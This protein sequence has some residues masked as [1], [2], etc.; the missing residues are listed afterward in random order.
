MD[1]NTF[2]TTWVAPVVTGVIVVVITT[3]IGKIVS[4]WW[5]NR[6]FVRNRDRANEKYI[7]NILPYMI[8]KIDVNADFVAS[9][10][11]ALSMQFNLQAKHLYSNEQLK[12]Q[13]ILSISDSKFMTELQ[14]SDLIQYVQS[15]FK[16]IGQDI[17]KVEVSRKE[18]RRANKKYPILMLVISVCCTLIVY[19]IYPEK[20][21]D[22][23]SFAHSLAILGGLFSLGSAATLWMMLLSESTNKINIEIADSGI[24][25]AAYTVVKDVV[26][27]ITEILLGKKKDT[28]DNE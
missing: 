15:T 13:I 27:T 21:D 2:I 9:V 14:K 26:S 4:I 1:I 7:D 16:N 6:T 23:N 3:G 17:E 20:V 28:D 8:Q 5:K 25:G 10:K 11:N 12:N 22:P 18:E 19:A 24:I